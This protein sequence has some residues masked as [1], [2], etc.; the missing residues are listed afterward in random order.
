MLQFASLV[1][2]LL[3]IAAV[4]SRAQAQ[5]V[6]ELTRAVDAW[7]AAAKA[8]DL[9]KWLSLRT[10]E[11]KKELTS[12]IGTQ[13]KKAIMFARMQ[14]ADSYQVQHVIWGKDGG[15]ATLFLLAKFAAMPEAERPTAM[16]MEESVAF[17]KES[18]AWKIDLIR[19][20]A[21]PDKIQRPTDLTYDPE[22]AKETSDASIGGRIVR[23][24]FKPDYTLVILRVMDEEDAVFLPPKDV[25][26]K[27]GETEET[28]A[29]WKLHEFHGHV[30]KTD[31]LK[32]FATGGKP[33]DE[34]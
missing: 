22:N 26:A 17:K 33:L 14:A 32:F 4:G 19:P 15:S 5:D 3:L 21:D 16:R 28:L 1:F 34:E 30:H 9:D 24:E 10:A 12:D 7:H 25:L 31:K 18:D 11:V 27:A 6:G 2:G 20:L 29:A 13:R 23:T 8:G